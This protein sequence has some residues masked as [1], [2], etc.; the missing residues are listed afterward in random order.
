VPTNFSPFLGHLPIRTVRH[1]TDDQ[2][3]ETTV[4]S[5]CTIHELSLCS[6]LKLWSS[7]RLPLSPFIHPSHYSLDLMVTGSDAVWNT[8]QPLLIVTK[9]P[10]VRGILDPPFLSRL[11][12]WTARTLPE[13]NFEAEKFFPSEG[14]CFSRLPSPSPTV[15]PLQSCVIYLFLFNYSVCC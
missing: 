7:S 2:M 11:K 15:L 14:I 1:S 9:I 6:F 3:I 8:Y 12:S 4:F 5:I 13:E 10:S